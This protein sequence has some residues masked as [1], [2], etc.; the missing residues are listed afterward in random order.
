MNQA[1]HHLDLY[2]WLAGRPDRVKATARTRIHEIEVENTVGALLEHGDDRVDS[3]YTTTAE[4]PGRTEFL[5]RGTLGTLEAVDGRLRLYRMERSLEEELLTSAHGK[6]PTG[7]WEDVDTD[8][9]PKGTGAH[10]LLLEHFCEAVRDGDP[11]KIVA[12]GEDGLHALELGNAMYLSSH[13]DETITMP[14]SREAYR[15]FLQSKI[16]EVDAAGSR[17]R[18]GLVE[19]KG[20][21]IPPSV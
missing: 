1:P 20:A 19:S 5:F 17:K 11:S 15:D 14:I 13:L 21:E 8:E 2:S 3:F 6:S 9:S 18:S 12:T 7:A 4:W 10:R 16:A